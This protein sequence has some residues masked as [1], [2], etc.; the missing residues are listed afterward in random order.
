MITDAI[1][2]VQDN[3]FRSALEELHH[4]DANLGA[5]LDNIDGEA[6]HASLTP[7][8]RAA[9]S[10]AQVEVLRERAQRE[11]RRGVAA[12]HK[13]HDGVAS[14]IRTVKLNERVIGSTFERFFSHIEAGIQFLDK[15]G[16][17]FVT[18]ANA[19]KLNDQIAEMVASLEKE[20]V[21]DLAAIRTQLEMVD[22]ANFLQPTYANPAAAHEVQMRTPLSNR[23]LNVIIK[24]D[25]ILSSLVKLHWN[26][27][28]ERAQIEHQESKCK[29][30]IR[31]LAFFLRRTT[32]NMKQKVEAKE[33]AL[34]ATTGAGIDAA[35][36]QS[37]ALQAAA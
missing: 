14:M 19:G 13:R 5:S 10:E 30:G 26:G 1:S 7:A 3:E 8:A 9:V 29:S 4:T 32:R 15:R 23:V 27:E 18:A 28:I 36:E 22:S 2:P 12:L 31:N 6:P 35:N 17:M 16:V 25:E 24:H 20:A 21:A 33:A 11:R 37:Q 34:E